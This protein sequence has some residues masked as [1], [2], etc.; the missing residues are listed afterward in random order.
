M[1]SQLTSLQ[2]IS[3]FRVRG[4]LCGQHIVTLIDTSATHNFIDE[5]VVAR[6]CIE[7]KKM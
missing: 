2:K 4:V 1:I 3:Y 7:T 5:G 6:R